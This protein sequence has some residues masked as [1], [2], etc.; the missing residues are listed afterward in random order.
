M[1]T[2]PPIPVS[3]LYVCTG[4][5][6][7]SPLAEAL[8]QEYARR[9]GVAGRL[10]ITSAGTHAWEG[11]AATHEAREAARL[12]GLDLSGHRAR[13]VRESILRENDIVLCATQQHHKWLQREFPRHENKLYLALLFPRRLTSETP[14]ETDIPDPIGETVEYYIEVLKMLEPTL[15]II[16]S[17]ALRDK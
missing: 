1:S 9:Q 3:I 13:E 8:L 4:N 7:R 15:P 10:R 11:N 2:K 14:P 5:I 6:C 17:S 12:W 16:L